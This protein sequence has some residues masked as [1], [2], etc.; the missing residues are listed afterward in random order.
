MIQGNSF[1]HTL[2]KYKI[3]Q[4]ETRYDTILNHYNWSFYVPQV[5][6]I[7]VMQDPRSF[8]VFLP[9]TLNSENFLNK[10]LKRFCFPYF[11]QEVEN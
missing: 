5:G 3:N 11:F 9:W 8:L 4:I 10:I 1:F 6:N 7:F 2:L